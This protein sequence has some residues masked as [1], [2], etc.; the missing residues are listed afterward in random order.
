MQ[1][2]NQLPIF[3]DVADFK[4]Y[5]VLTTGDSDAI[6]IATAFGTARGYVTTVNDGFFI[7]TGWSVWTNYDN[8]GGVAET[9]AVTA[10]VLAGP[11]FVPNNFRVQIARSQNN[12]FSN[13]PLTQAE[14]CS[15]GYHSGKQAPLPILYAPNVTF[16]FQFTDTTGLYLLTAADAAIPLQIR[17]FM[18]GLQVPKKAFG[19]LLSYFPALRGAG[20]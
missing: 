9:A 7:F 14:L 12:T 13:L 4:A 3:S 16:D 15:S 17:L 1:T 2:F 10:S 20:Y 8:A 5:P 6:S 18:V 19:R 11:P